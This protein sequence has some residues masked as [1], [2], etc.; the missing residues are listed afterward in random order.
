V[1]AHVKNSVICFEKQLYIFGIGN[2]MVQLEG[3][4]GSIVWGCDAAVGECGGSVA[5]M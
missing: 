3:C 5:G 1:S 4:G 2:V